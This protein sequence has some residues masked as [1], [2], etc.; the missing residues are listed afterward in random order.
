MKKIEKILIYIF[1]IE[2]LF[3]LIVYS[4]DLLNGNNDGEIKNILFKPVGIRIGL[5]TIFIL[6]LTKLGRNKNYIISI[7]S[8]NILSGLII[9]IFFEFFSCLFLYSTS[10]NEYFPSH[11]LFYK[12]PKYHLTKNKKYYLDNNN[13]YG[14]WRSPNYKLEI[15]RCSDKKNIIY[16]SNSL[17]A[18]DKE[19]LITG[20]NRVVFL[21][22]SFTE[23]I[24][25]DE[26]KR[27]S[28]LLESKTGSEFLN[29]GIIGANP[30]QYYTIYNTLISNKIEHNKIIIGIFTGNDFDSDS[31]LSKTKQLEYPNYRPY[32]EKV[33][34]KYELRFTLDDYKESIDSQNA[35]DNNNV[36]YDTRKKLYNSLSLKEKMKV[37]IETNSYFYSVIRLIIEKK[38]RKKMENLYNKIYELPNNYVP[39]TDFTYSL[40]KIINENKEKEILLLLI[41]AKEQ[42]YNFKSNK[43]NNL[44]PFIEKNIAR[45]NCTIIDLLPHF[46]NQPNIE[47]FFIKCD[48]HWNDEGNLF[49]SKILLN[50]NYFLEFL[51]KK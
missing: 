22:D 39:P 49:A 45:N 25:I 48:G 31:N 10:K 41:P 50:N 27:L 3:F 35:C 32:W 18:R 36:I 20:K 19:R 4:Y 26:N 46:A 44:T 34:N 24:L 7:I 43:I 5:F 9:L 38:E 16:S 15:T 8:S 11:I 2:I 14:R 29:F 6:L 17:G 21:G 28:N 33:N 13:N 42:I 1:Y 30:I 51:S 12:N 47:K 37:E 23:G 40:Q